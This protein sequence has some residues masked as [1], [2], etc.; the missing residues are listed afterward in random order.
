M[1][2]G[3]D[4]PSDKTVKSTFLV[5]LLCC[6][7]LHLPSRRVHLGKAQTVE[8]GR[9]TAASLE[10]VHH[11]DLAIQWRH[12]D[13]RMSH[14]HAQ[15]TVRNG[16]WKLKD[17][18]SKNG[19]WVNHEVVDEV[20]LHDGDVIEI[21]ASFFLFRDQ[22]ECP[23]AHTQDVKEEA[24]CR[25][26]NPRLAGL[27]ESATRVADSNL[28][29]I[30][31]GST[32][33]GKEVWAQQFHTASG[34]KGQ[35]VPLNCG[36][37]PE[38]LLE[39]QLFGHV[40]GAFSGAVADKPGMVDQAN[41]GTLFLDEIGDLP[42]S[43]QVKLLRLLQENECQ[44]VGARQPHQV[45]VRI[46]AASHKNLNKLV[47]EGLFR[48]DLLARLSGFA[49]TLPDFAQ[50]KED[51][52]MLFRAAVENSFEASPAVTREAMR[53][54]LV[55]SWPQNIRQLVQ[56]VHGAAALSRGTAITVKTLAELGLQGNLDK[57]QKLLDLLQ[58]HDGNVS[59]VARVMGKARVQVR[60]WC[61]SYDIDIDSFRK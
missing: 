3:D 23:I 18:G 54:L 1:T 50:R 49:V 31:S 21:G 53:L 41:G 28:P 5:H 56:T 9:G 17:L 59:A 13:A 43:A 26:L 45:D 33:T 37:I 51:F 47:A 39:S 35:W 25:S 10:R 27:L 14:N 34:R 24:S 11:A 42:L 15:M 6:E 19:T 29:M 8:I 16:Q 7:D 4:A 20:A 44:P 36:A 12:Q 38:N 55:Q 61:E 32:G 60:R 46:I 52:G 48:E 57:K 58:L 30:L 22:F 40:K 2:W